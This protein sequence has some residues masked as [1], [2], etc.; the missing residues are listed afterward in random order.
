MEPFPVPLG[1][2]GVMVRFA[3]PLFAFGLLLGYGTAAPVPKSVKPVVGE[4]NTNALVKAHRQKLVTAA[5]S[6]WDSWPVA[7]LFDGN[8]KTSWYSN[9]GEA[10]QNGKNPTI[11]VTFPENVAVKRVTVLGNRDPQYLEGYFVLEGKIE[12]LDKDD[13]VLSTH[14][15]KGAGEKHDFDLV[16]TK[17]TTLRAVRFTATKDEGR[18][19]CVGLGEFQIE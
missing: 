11:K 3:I 16:L 7:H 8:D 4:T 18:L 19:G 15:L 9:N 6:E 5:S 2:E 10:P 14:E 13:K 12:L 1:S 17:L